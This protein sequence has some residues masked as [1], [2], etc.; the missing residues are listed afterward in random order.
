MKYPR[1][2]LILAS[3]AALAKGPPLVVN[4]YDADS[5]E[6]VTTT[7]RQTTQVSATSAVLITKWQD[8]REGKT[9]TQTVLVDANSSTL[10]WKLTEDGGDTDYVGERDGD[11]VTVRGSLR[12]EAVDKEHDV[13]D[14][15]FYHSPAVG[16][17]AF[18]RSGAQ[19]IEFYTVRPDDLSCHKMKAERKDSEEITVGDVDVQAVRVKWGLTGLRSAFY[20]RTFWFREADGVFLRSNKSRGIYSELVPG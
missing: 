8:H 7:T 13:G 18:V 10:S 15:A 6:L 2:V 9:G 1:W 11:T 20:K 3:A 4:T 19:K 5:G 12:G 17:E 14:L 16:L